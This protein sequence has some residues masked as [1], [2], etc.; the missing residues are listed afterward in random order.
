MTCTSTM[1][2]P[3][4]PLLTSQ[5]H[6]LSGPLRLNQLHAPC[7]FYPSGSRLTLED[8]F[9][10][11]LLQVAKGARELHPESCKLSI[12]PFA[13]IITAFL[14]RISKPFLNKGVS[15]LP[16]TYNI[17]I[18]ECVICVILLLFTAPLWRDYLFC[19]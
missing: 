18:L 9:F 13:L 10:T 19:Y 8:L 3:S 14:K 6:I 7:M 1:L 12:F 2:L 5:I 16:V 11:C 15:D 17:I 4:Y